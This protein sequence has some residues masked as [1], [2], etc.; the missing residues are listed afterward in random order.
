MQHESGAFG[1]KSNA[2]DLGN[3]RTCVKMEIAASTSHLLRTGADCAQCHH[4][5]EALPPKVAARGGRSLV[6]N[7]ST[8]TIDNSQGTA[9]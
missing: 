4:H 5:E 1:G 9:S 2:Y 3:L 7:P 6:I 8:Y